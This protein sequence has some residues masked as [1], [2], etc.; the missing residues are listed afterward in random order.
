LVSIIPFIRVFY[1]IHF[2]FYYQHGWHLEGVNI[3]ESVLSM[4]QGDPLGGP[5]YVLAHSRAS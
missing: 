4:R 2:S 1:A 5:L 3:I